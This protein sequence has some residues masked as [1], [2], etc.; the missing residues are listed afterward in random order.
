MV[1]FDPLQSLRF[2]KTSFFSVFAEIRGTEIKK[3]QTNFKQRYIQTCR[4]RFLMPP[5]NY[6]A[7]SDKSTSNAFHFLRFRQSH[8]GL[9]LCET[10]VLKLA[11]CLTES[12][13][14][15]IIQPVNQESCVFQRP[16]FL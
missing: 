5:K 8:E 9:K 12:T 14:A 15:F 2:T 10:S 11:V 16:C 3:K 1:S 6:T 4:F 7:K 13:K